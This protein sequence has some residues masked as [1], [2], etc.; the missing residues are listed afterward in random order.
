MTV[1]SGW[2]ACA[3]MVERVLIR[4]QTTSASVPDDAFS[5]GFEPTPQN[6]VFFAKKSLR[7]KKI[8][9]YINPAPR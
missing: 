1:S 4:A 5:P 3:K 6:R 9:S 7:Y 2:A 8:I